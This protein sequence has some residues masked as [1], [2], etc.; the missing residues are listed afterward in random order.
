MTQEIIIGMA[1]FVMSVGAVLYA[2]LRRPAYVRVRR[3]SREQS[4]VR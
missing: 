4:R 1:T 3:A 2:Q